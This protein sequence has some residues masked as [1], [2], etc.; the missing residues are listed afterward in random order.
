LPAFVKTTVGKNAPY[1]IVIPAKVGIQV[2]Y[3]GMDVQSISFACI[4]YKQDV[5]PQEFTQDW[6]PDQVGC[7]KAGAGMTAI[8]KCHGCKPVSIY[9]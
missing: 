3:E 2:F 6:T 4:P 5:T 8:R 1:C 7:D 9:L